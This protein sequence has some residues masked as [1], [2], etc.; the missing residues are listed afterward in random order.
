MK[1][2]EKILIREMDVKSKHQY[3]V[4]RSSWP[5]VLLPLLNETFSV[6][7]GITVWR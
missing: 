2:T 7:A 4:C 3:N 1:K 5:M 6:F